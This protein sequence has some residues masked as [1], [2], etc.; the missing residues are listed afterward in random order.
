MYIIYLSFSMIRNS[1]TFVIFY[2][3]LPLAFKGNI[4]E[5]KNLRTVQTVTVKLAM[6]VAQTQPRRLICINIADPYLQA[7]W[8]SLMYI[9][10]VKNFKSFVIS[11]TFNFA[12]DF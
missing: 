12:I 11:L 4:R 3:T 9:S 7:V 2:Q 8:L 10:F 1:H 5:P 6:F